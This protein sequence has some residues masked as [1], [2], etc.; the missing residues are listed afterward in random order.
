MNRPCLGAPMRK[1]I[2]VYYS[3][4]GLNPGASAVEIRRAYLR[5][6]QRWHPDHFKSGSYMHTTAED[7]TKELNEA[8]EQLYK[9][10]LYKK[11]LPRLVPK[12][13]APEPA[14]SPADRARQ[15]YGTGMR[16]DNPSAVLPKTPKAESPAGRGATPVSPEP[17]RA[18][19]PAP[20]DPPKAQRPAPR[21]R[22]P[23]ATPASPAAKPPAPAKKVP[24]RR[25]HSWPWNKTVVVIG[26][27]VAGFAIRQTMPES[28][29]VFPMPLLVAAHDRLPAR[30]AVPPVVT[31]GAAMQ[32]QVATAEVQDQASRAPTSPKF[33]PRPVL[34]AVLQP[35][36]V[37][38]N[39]EESPSSTARTAEWARILDDARAQMETFQRGDNK[40]KVVSIQGAPDEAG[41]AAFRYGSSVVYFQAGLVT[42]WSDGFPRLRV[43]TRAE[44]GFDLLNT[45][46]VGS[47]RAEVFRAQGAPT[48][49]TPGSY[50]YG[51]SAVNFENDRVTDWIQVDKALSTLVIPTMPSVD[52]DKLVGR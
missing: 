2:H 51:A 3:A 30:S 25:F 41:E 5:R 42:G 31:P 40:S 7:L 45:F 38:Q 35:K 4:L 33:T 32:N 15:A 1:E 11:F 39:P 29:I 50:Y 43:P 18:K 12:K 22:F 52:L 27:I 21:R 46:S 9:K 6:I 13:P 19:P 20:F 48:G 24:T 26:L 49:L 10:Q 34:P 16:S 44:M 17:P 8:Y 14:A 23:R 28:Y 47:S 37:A 36:P